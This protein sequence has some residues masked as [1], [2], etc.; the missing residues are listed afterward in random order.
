MSARVPEEAGLQPG[1]RAGQMA[2][3]VPGAAGPQDAGEGLGRGRGGERNDDFV[4]PPADPAEIAR[5]LGQRRSSGPVQVAAQ[6]RQV[7]AVGQV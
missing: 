3:P 6:Q 2:G 4:G 1:R 5:V 7:A